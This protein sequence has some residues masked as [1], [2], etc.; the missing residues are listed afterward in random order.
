MF[1]FITKSFQIWNNVKHN[2]LNM[3]LYEPGSIS[4]MN[5]TKRLIITIKQKWCPSHYDGKEKCVCVC[6]NA[7]M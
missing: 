6:V 7:I 2:F 4:L 5:I 3:A 1:N